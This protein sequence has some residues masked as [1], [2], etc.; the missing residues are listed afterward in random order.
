M[1][2]QWYDADQSIV[3]NANISSYDNTLFD[4]KRLEYKCFIRNGLSNL[5]YRSGVKRNSKYISFAGN[6]VQ[7]KTDIQSNSFVFH[8]IKKIAGERCEYKLFI[9]SDGTYFLTLIYSLVIFL[10][11][12]SFKSQNIF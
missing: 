11:T 7:I 9:C 4:M 2:L 10:S 3:A 6:T 1:L 8:D 5:K 12:R